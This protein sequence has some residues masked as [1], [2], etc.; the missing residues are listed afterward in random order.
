MPKKADSGDTTA[1]LLAY[2][3]GPGDRDE[4]TDPHLV[5]AWDP[6]LPCPARIPDRMTLSTLGQLL[7]APVDALRG[8]RPAEHVWHTSIRNAPTDR[9]LTDTEW[10]RVAAEMVHV[11]GIAPH[12]DEQACRWV[13][14]RHAP[15][16]IH[17]VATL[18][19]R[20]GN[21]P[22]IRGDIPRMHTAARAFETALGL[23]A[24]SPLDQTASRAPVTG[25]K[26]KA[27][28]RGLTEPARATLQ[29]AVREA[30]ALAT[31]DTDFLTRLRDAGL[32][33]REHHDE[34]GAVDGYAVALPG[35]RADHG[36]RPVWFSGRTLAYDLSL[37]RIRERFHPTISPADLTRAH[38]RIREAAALLARA[39]RTQGAGDV[40]AL[41]DLLTVTAAVSPTTV[42]DQVQAAAARFE[43][44]SRAPGTRTLQGTAR[45]HFKA[46]TRAL[47]HAPRTARAGG[48]PAVLNLLIALIEAVE[49]ATAWHRAHDDHAQ[50]TAAA[51]AAALLR[52][53]ADLTGTPA[54]T[55][56]PPRTPPRTVRVTPA[57]A[58]GPATP[59]PVTAVPTRPPTRP[60]PAP[61][62]GPAPGP[63]PGPGRS[64]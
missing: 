63:A 61:R 44:A 52:E 64:R 2:L 39:G 51:Q 12:G 14:V 32:R 13:A 36:T 30:A 28:R 56:T 33:V 60:H 55:T 11:A 18:A 48:A 46:A 26:E 41:G 43:Q 37:P 4:H 62:P 38:T 23:Q 15:D 47:E 42:R 58:R 10:A 20:D 5:A 19:R 25:E 59:P 24:M 1:G 22:R 40:A 3:F 8:P 7:D 17:L 54:R 57:P 53:A 27:T 50:A 21:G 16:H 35:D 6:A 29:R 49:A 45:T 9:T 31:G 34:N